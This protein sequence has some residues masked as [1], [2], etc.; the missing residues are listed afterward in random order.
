MA[1]T[2][3]A[4]RPSAWAGKLYTRATQ[5]YQESFDQ[6]L[7]TKALNGMSPDDWGVL[8]EDALALCGSPHHTFSGRAWG[9]EATEFLAQFV[10]PELL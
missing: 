7:L 1:I 6:E 9:P 4:D 5:R 3:T 8:C 10:G 2:R